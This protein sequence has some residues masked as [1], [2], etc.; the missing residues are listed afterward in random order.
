MQ[1][2]VHVHQC[3][4]AVGHGTFFNGLALDRERNSSF[5][6]IYDCGS[7]RTTRIGHEIT[8]LLEWRLIWPK[9][10]D[11]LVL[12]HFD[13]DHVNGIEQLLNS[14]RVQT[15]ALPY[16]DIG[17]RLACAAS[18]SA[19]PC[20]ASTA[21]LQLDP[22]AWLQSRGLTGQVDTILLVQGGPRGDNDPPVDGGTVPLPSGPADNQRLQ[23]DSTDI[24]GTATSR[25]AGTAKAGG[26]TVAPRIVSWRH[27]VSAQAGNIPLE[28]TFFN[29]TQP[30]LFRND[31]NGGLIAR[32]SRCPTSVVQIDV[33][34]IM[35]R[36]G[37]ADLGGA[38]RR[39]WRD[40][41]RTV[42]AK[43]F[44]NSSQQRNNISLCLLVRPAGEKVGSCEIFTCRETLYS[45]PRRRVSSINRA[46]TLLL[47]DLRIDNATL[48]DMQAHFGVVRWRDL[49]TVQV[50]HH[51][52]LHSWQRGAAKLFAPDRFV[53]CVPDA[54]A[55]H[56][57]P[58][59]DDDLS[60][61]AVL[62][63]DYERGIAIDY[64]FS[65]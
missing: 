42:Y 28:L 41:L 50:P 1:T 38:P 48:A 53:H 16:I 39:G 19:D 47:G 58:S 29:A 10:V 56:P 43:H 60:G 57:H 13:D 36:Y 46:G 52:S 45:T 12:S 22:V 35:R 31:A 54:S 40:A 63:A 17:H 32:R 20:S 49:G 11:L 6:W 25:L 59:V 23:R 24:D 5:S 18:L 4:N 27:A 65:A 33:E 44:G 51:G 15:L 37:L 64:H 21:A 2:R 55:H 26:S 9:E 61:H 7:K 3:F 34:V 62:R 30:S 8:R 14:T